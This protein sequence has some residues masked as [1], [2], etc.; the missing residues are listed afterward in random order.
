MSSFDTSKLY[1]GICSNMVKSRNAWEMAFARA[2][3]LHAIASVSCAIDT[4]ILE[5]VTLQTEGVD[6][7]ACYYTD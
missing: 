6:E 7:N 3:D 4:G 2:G 5:E 1:R